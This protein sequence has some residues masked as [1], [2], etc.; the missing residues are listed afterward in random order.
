MNIGIFAYGRTGCK[1]ADRFKR[2]EKRTMNHVSEFIMAADTSAAQLHSL[3]RIDEDWKL[4]YGRGEFEG[5]GTRADLEPAVEA[6]KKTTGNI[7]KA[8]NS[9]SKDEIDAFVVMGSLGG[10]TGGGGAPICAK[11]L[12]DQFKNIPVY[13]VGVL[14]STHEPDLFTLNTAR[15]LQSFSRE[16]DNI[17]LFD[18]DHLGVSLPDY[19]P[20]VP[21]DTPPGDVFG[22]VNQD[23]A[24]CLHM[25]FTADEKKEPS[26]LTDTTIDTDTLTKVLGTG[27]LST[28]CYT[29][30]TLPRPA[31]PGI[32]GRFFEMIEYVRYK[33]ATRKYE[34][35]HVDERDADEEIREE[36]ME[37]EDISVGT[38]PDSSVQ[39][40]SL[41]ALFTEDR[42]I[43]TG[44][45]PDAPHNERIKKKE[46]QLVQEKPS[47]ERDWPHPTK[48]VPLTL[49]PTTAMMDM[50]PAQT[51][52]NLFLLVAPKKHLSR[53]QV[54]A[55]ADW[56]DEHTTS[57]FPVAK[58]YPMKNK[59]V[60]VLSLCSGIGIPERI[61]E[62]Q[63]EA[64]TIAQ[65]IL[66]KKQ[67]N[68][69]PKDVNIFEN[70]QSKVP[71]SF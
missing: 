62:I 19:N 61:S 10:G 47:L 12:S 18:N 69:N 60:G 53:E 8:T 14:P 50:N 41:D 7:A 71:P 45:L 1:I 40:G 59:N 66:K 16:T 4:V 24:R 68:P 58:S 29:K 70:N 2:F 32:I 30:Q 31:R 36:D 67:E 38:G 35:Q 52:R 6:A 21:D 3:Q 51:S 54:V 23:I 13:G 46:T 56:A 22:D 20:A 65:R 11:V 44:D 42:E 26:H 39:T 5:K 49:D 15:A 17:L 64:D 27:G 28:M 25:L 43:N 34:Q 37:F 9:V 48:L 55:T 57:G 33:H 63:D